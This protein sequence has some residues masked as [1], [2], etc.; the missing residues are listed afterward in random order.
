MKTPEDVELKPSGDSSIKKNEDGSAIQK[1][2]VTL[3]PYTIGE[4]VIEPI[5]YSVAD[6]FGKTEERETKSI[7][8]TVESVRGEEGDKPKDIRANV[9]IQQRWREYLLDMAIIL[10]IIIAG[11]L[12]WRWWSKRV[13][14]EVSPQATLVPK[15]SAHEIAYERLEALEAQKRKGEVEKRELFFI[16]S[17]I[18]REYLE[19][20][21]P[22]LALERTTPELKMELKNGFLA[23][24]TKA[25]LFDLLELCD[26]IKFAKTEPEEEWAN[27]SIVQATAFVEETRKRPVEEI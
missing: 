18:V 16:V 11:A 3:T 14:Q 20:R 23:D 27:R 10:A 15:K 25:G 19:N 4:I 8:F 7:T 22:I 2:A 13:T 24:N 5:K 9:D 6:A 17:E 21:Y 26:F 1:F 12:L